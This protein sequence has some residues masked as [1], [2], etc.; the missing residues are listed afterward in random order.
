MP[1]EKR[2]RK[3]SSGDW[4]VNWFFRRCIQILRSEEWQIQMKPNLRLRHEGEQRSEVLCGMTD[5]GNNIIYLNP[6]RR[7]HPTSDDLAKTLVHELA[8]ILFNSSEDDKFV[9][10]RNIYQIEKIWDRFSENQR[11]AL[12]SFIPKK[13]R[14]K[15]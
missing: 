3:L 13:Y 15:K 7:K 2:D 5:F 12:L 6:S 8:H 4:L 14:Q 9:S 10:H 11:K 1:R